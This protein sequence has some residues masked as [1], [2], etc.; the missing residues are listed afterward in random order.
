MKSEKPQQ[1]IKKLFFVAVFGFV[2]AACNT[3]VNS[4]GGEVSGGESEAVE[5]VVDGRFITGEPA[6][7]VRL[8]SFAGEDIELSQWYGDTAIVLDFWAGW[9]PFCVGE[10][11]ALQKAQDAYRDDLVIVGVHRTDTES[12]AA[13]KRFA[14]DLGV[15]YLLVEDDGSLYRAVG[16]VGMPVAVY[17]DS[18]GVVQEIKSGPK[19]EEEIRQRAEALLL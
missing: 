7:P 16:G 14:D 13:G 17:I 6:P 15:S 5:V 8:Q 9:C 4:D 18:D 3:A 10:M 19:T 2:V 11:P 12:V 1:R